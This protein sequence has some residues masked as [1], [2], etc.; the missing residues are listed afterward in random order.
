MT[1]GHLKQAVGQML[2]LTCLRRCLPIWMAAC[3]AA[4]MNTA[5]SAKPM[6]AQAQTTLDSIWA[7]KPG[8]LHSK[9]ANNDSVH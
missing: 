4:S 8:N 3:A 1:T 9:H 7:L 2:A 5:S 6:V